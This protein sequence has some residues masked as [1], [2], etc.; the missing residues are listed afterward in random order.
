MKTKY[1]YRP[2]ANAL[3]ILYILKEI[4]LEPLERVWWLQNVVLFLLN[5][6]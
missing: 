2:A 4:Y 6:I 5:E 1:K 3:C